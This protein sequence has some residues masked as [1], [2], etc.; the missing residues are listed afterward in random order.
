MLRL[1][2]QID[3]AMDEWFAR[4]RTLPAFDQH[5]IVE[6]VKVG[7]RCDTVD[8]IGPALLPLDP[9]LAGLWVAWQEALDAAAWL[10]TLQ[11]VF[12]KRES[13]REEAHDA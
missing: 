11:T 5:A 3:A 10:A 7:I 12:V 1:T 9:I 8:E 6:A 2:T 13:L 4:L